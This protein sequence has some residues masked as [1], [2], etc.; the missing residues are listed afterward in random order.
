MAQ[1]ADSP[2]EYDFIIY[3]GQDFSRT[4]TIKD[5]NGDAI[6]ISGYDARLQVR[7]NKSSS[8]SVLSLTVGDGLSIT[9]A[10]GQVTV[11]LTATETAALDYNGGVYDLELVDG[12]DVVTRILE[13]SATL[14]KEVT[15]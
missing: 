10:S 7:E 2:G 13:G 12:S 5:S 15:R 11:S 3:Q 8:S 14:D 6:D 1:L 4:F 9:G